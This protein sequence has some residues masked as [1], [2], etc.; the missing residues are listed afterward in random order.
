MNRRQFLGS[1]F[2]SS[3]AIGGLLKLSPSL[4]LPTFESPSKYQTLLLTDGNIAV[5]NHLSSLARYR[6]IYEVQP[7]NLSVSSVIINGELINSQ[8]LG[9]YSSLDRLR[10]LSTILLASNPQSAEAY[11]QAAQIA[12]TLHEFSLSED[13]LSK[14]EKLNGNS[15]DIERIKLSIFQATGKDQDRLLTLRKEK[16]LASQAS[17]DL[18]PYAALLAENNKVELANSIYLKAINT[19]HKN[20]SPFIPAWICFQLGS[21]W[22]EI[23][24]PDNKELASFW[25]TKALSY[26]PQYTKA[27]IHLSETLIDSGKN[28]LALEILQPA[29]E[30]TDPEVSWRLSEIYTIKNRPELAEQYLNFAN[31]MFLSLLDK[32]PLAFA[33]HGAEFYSSSGKNPDKAHALALLNYQNRPTDRAAHLLQKSKKLLSL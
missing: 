33:D 16:A 31:A 12:G 21:L 13:H 25:Y 19:Q 9:D 3:L 20:L 6:R 7:T 26:M 18:L 28:D 14:A 2:G 24:K 23:A 15:S 27:R 32:H 5:N 30:S 10:H 1:A 8:F 17:E 22:G 29:I 11:I 4:A